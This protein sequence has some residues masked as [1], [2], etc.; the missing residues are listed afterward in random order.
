MTNQNYDDSHWLMA[1]MM[2]KHADVVISLT[3]TI[4]DASRPSIMPT[5]VIEKQGLKTFFSKSFLV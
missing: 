1:V 4:Q 3:F 5:T 2:P